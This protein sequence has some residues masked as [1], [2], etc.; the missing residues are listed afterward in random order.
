MSHSVPSDWSVSD[1]IFA[2]PSDLVAFGGR[3]TARATARVL[4]ADAGNDAPIDGVSLDLVYGE[5]GETF[6]ASVPLAEEPREFVM[7]VADP[8]VLLGNLTDGLILPL[9]EPQP[10]FGLHVP[11]SHTP[12]M[13]AVYDFIGDP[14]TLLPVHDGAGWDLTRPDWF[15]EHHV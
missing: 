10:A 6:V 9:C 12:G 4:W 7:P 15:Y 5:P 1:G 2:V 11:A 8:L 3:P 13:E 14:H